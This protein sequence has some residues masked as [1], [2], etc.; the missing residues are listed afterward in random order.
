MSTFKFDGKDYETKPL[1]DLHEKYP[2]GLAALLCTEA[3]AS[4]F[5]DAMN[6]LLG[7]TIIE[8]NQAELHEAWEKK[9]SDKAVP[10]ISAPV[11]PG[12]VIGVDADCEIIGVWDVPL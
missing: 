9:K 12:I 8:S 3:T 11:I 6:R 7:F 5:A 10:M 1:K 2:E 4:A